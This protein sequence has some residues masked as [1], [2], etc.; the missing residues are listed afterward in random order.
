[1]AEKDFKRKIAAILSAIVEGYIRLMD[2]DKAATVRTLKS[3]RSAVNDLA[4]NIVN[5][6]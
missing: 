5:V 2:H 4:S 3:Y 6:L 1:M